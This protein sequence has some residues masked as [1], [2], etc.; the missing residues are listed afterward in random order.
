MLAVTALPASYGDCIWIEYGDP[1]APHV[2]LI[3]AGPSV[4]GGLKKRLEDLGERGGVLDLVVVTHIDADHIGG[5]LKLIE[6]DFYGVPVRDFWFNG[7]RHLPDEGFG[8]KQGERLT[9]LIVGKQY[10]WNVA[11]KNSALQ[12]DDRY[13][14]KFDL[15][16]EATITLLSPGM[17]QLRTLQR[18]WT[19]VCD[20]AGLHDHLPAATEFFGRNDKE[21]FGGQPP[22]V[23]KLSS[24]LFA[25]DRAAANGS[26]IAFVLEHAGKKVLLGAD[27]F[28]SRLLKSLRMTGAAPFDFDLVKL[29]HHGSENNVSV[30]LIEALR[31]PRYLFSSDG[32]KF[33][34][35]SR[36]AV[37]R[38]IKHG[39][40][41][42][43]IF[44]YWGSFTSEWQNALLQA[45]YGYK[46]TYGD[47]TGYTVELT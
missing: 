43:L 33:S 1:L 39:R 32:A 36:Q 4:P 6:M 19:K 31:S 11:T 40:R 5:M 28:P 45:R 29:P 12:V 8:P 25:E 44:N 10:A 2:I 47:E 34:H 27:A 17:D 30:E 14:P 23:D 9:G 38:V 24:E 3:D 41:P 35:P 42:E 16:G 46:A 15:P 20:E 37:A 21:V 26:S 13:P 22:D 18:E 7:F